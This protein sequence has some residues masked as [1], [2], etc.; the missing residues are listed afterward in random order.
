MNKTPLK[1]PLAVYD[2]GMQDRLSITAWKV[3]VEEL[4]E[5]QE[6]I[7]RLLHRNVAGQVRQ[8]FLGYFW[9]AM[10][11]LATAL[12]FS[13][14]QRS[15]VL[16]VH[17]PD[18]SMP[19]TLFALIGATIWGFFSQVTS[20]AT[21][22]V[23]GAGLLVSK[24]YFPREVL[25][26]SGVGNALVNLMIRLGVIL[27]SFLLSGYAPHWQIVFAPLL[28]IPVFAFA[29]GLGLFFAPIHTIMND[30]GRILEFL[31][32]FGM[33]LAPTVYPT[34]SLG[35]ATSVWGRSLF[36]LHS[37]NPV[38]HYMYAINDLIEKG[39]FVWTTGLT[40]STIIAFTS[41][42]VGW[43]FFHVCEPLL[44]ERI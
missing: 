26:V 8:S 37:L 43:R 2:A 24:I 29:L 13:M 23:F 33:Y 21:Q 38:S 27:L 19:Y 3:M 36:W 12:V 35:D 18:G 15:N 40:A 11:P 41:L 17:L 6:L 25:V 32:S 20:M 34:P 9:I 28:L 7:L 39:T 4:V 22:S 10:P 5:F 14:L 1:P 30:T 42:L 16:A 31:L 44:A